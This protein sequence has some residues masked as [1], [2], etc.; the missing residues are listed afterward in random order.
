MMGRDLRPLR[1]AAAALVLILVPAAALAASPA[2]APAAE[3][4]AGGQTTGVIRIA[5]ILT[6][7]ALIPALLVCM[8]SFVRIVVV[9]SMIRHAFGMPETPP[10]QVLVSLALLLTAFSMAPTFSALNERALQPFLAGDVTDFQQERCGDLPV[11]GSVGLADPR[12]VPGSRPLADSS[13]SLRKPIPELWSAP[14][15]VAVSRGLST[16][17]CLRLRFRMRCAR[18]RRRT[19][20]ET[21]SMRPSRYST[22]R[23]EACFRPSSCSST[24]AGGSSRNA[25]MPSSLTASASIG[26]HRPGCAPGSRAARTRRRLDGDYIEALPL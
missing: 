22:A 25:A 5:L 23:F 8:T 18:Q 13:R 16:P 10:N 3:A 9:L 12:L 11:L 19:S 21:Q 2:A 1:L 15:R 4:L 24:V 17:R 20:P 7:M 26:D 14:P 6:L